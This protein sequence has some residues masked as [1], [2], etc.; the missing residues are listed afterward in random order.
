ME[1]G[2]IDHFMSGVSIPVAGL[3]SAESCGVGEFADL[4]L[5]GR[6]CADAGLEVIQVLPVNDTGANASPY[7]ALSAFALHPLYLRLQEVPG[8]APH[9][10]EI[11]RFRREAGARDRF[12][13]AEVLSFK[14]SIVERAF[15]DT[16]SSVEKDPGFTR[17]R[18]ANPWVKP[19][20]A[21][22]A[23]KAANGG[24]PWTHWPGP[25]TD[26]AGGGPSRYPAT[27][28]AGS[29]PSPWTGKAGGGPSRYPA[30]LD[31]GSPPGPHS[32]EA[33]VE[34]VWKT[35]RGPCLFH[36]WVQYLLENQLD[37]AAGALRDMGVR[38]KGDIPI[39]MSEDSVD[40]WY[41]T[42]YFDRSVL[43][44]APPDVFA[45]DGQNW[46]FPVY[47]WD[48]LAADGYSWWKGRLLQAA[49][50]FN[51][52]RIDHVL[53]FF[54]IWC[55]P[56]TEKR[57]I[58]GRFSP[59]AFITARML[60]GAG[61]DE[62]RVRWLSTPHARGAELDAVFG[63]GAF[64]ARGQYFDRVGKEDLFTIKPALDS[65]TA[66]L[67]LEAPAEVKDYLR[68]K[69][70]DRALI[71]V[72]AEEYLTSWYFWT[73][74]P[75][76]GMRADEQDKLRGLATAVRR[77]SE[78]IWD[79]RGRKL[80]TM[81]RDATDMLVCAEDLGDVPECVPRALSDLGILGLRIARWARNYNA[82]DSPFIPESDFPRLSVCTASVHDTSTLRAW[83]R[84]SPAEREA[85]A[86][87]MGLSGPVPETLDAALLKRIIGRLME[88]GSLL[89]VFQLQDL[90]DLDEANWRAD[91]TED[92]INVPG[93]V[94]EFNW[95]WRMPFPVE[96]LSRR[97]ELI[98][99]I[100]GLTDARKGRNLS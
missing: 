18:R 52:F 84:E 20:A 99:E 95:T 67:A 85:Y 69:H 32:R 54:R 2:K 46:G 38:L 100:R 86:R 6:F 92:R 33:D 19:Y 34:K 96:E 75:F 25:W 24:T 94:T 14:L 1:F 72:G 60:G 78:K 13:Y 30:T 63:K 58:L 49:K 90:L 81:L 51:A 80:L 37:A 9:L 74:T 82:P 97:A 42:R 79:E 12:S 89:C 64:D 28:D 50:F 36:A 91:P 61:L 65:E 73:T 76:Q 53:G 41:S 5:L 29:P 40:V 10:D 87:H 39:L 59:S 35:Q 31:A 44:G 15:N 43:A 68:E 88:C 21:F 57:G 83:W 23:L 8:A 3:R 27:L 98:R 4:P 22:K 26:K 77:E 55:I 11:Y 48:A 70:L 47:N 56:V 16:G 7:S 93:T 45:K 66:I 62:G 71:R 17:W